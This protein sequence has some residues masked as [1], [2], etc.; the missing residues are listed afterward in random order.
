MMNKNHKRKLYKQQ[1]AAK[2]VNGHYTYN[3]V[4]CYATED[5]VRIVNSF[6][7]NLNHT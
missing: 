5:A 1:D 3:I 7:Y 6:Y 2:L 4:P